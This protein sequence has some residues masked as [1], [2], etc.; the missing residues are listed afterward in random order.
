MPKKHRLTGTEIRAIKSAR[1]LHGKLFSLSYSPGGAH[2]RFSFVVSK[3]VAVRAVD[4]NLI[5][6][7]SRAITNTHVKKLAPGAYVLSAKREAAGSAYT[8][9]RSDI[10]DIIARL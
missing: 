6:R 5:K 7:R 3:K 8:M 2:P 4:R 9:M 10:A 1:R